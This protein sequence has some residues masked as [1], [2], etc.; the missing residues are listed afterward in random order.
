MERYHKNKKKSLISWLDKFFSNVSSISN[1]PIKHIKASFIIFFL[2]IVTI[3]RGHFYN[4]KFHYIQN[5]KKSTEEL[6]VEFLILKS[7]YEYNSKLSKI[8]K[9][10]NQLGL[11]L[12]KEPPVVI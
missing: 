7:N 5:L 3:F 6:R 10:A 9:R 4:K 12:S 2:G 11:F 1:L 8:E